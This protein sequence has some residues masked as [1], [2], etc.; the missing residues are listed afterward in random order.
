MKPTEVLTEPADPVATSPEN[1]VKAAPEVDIKR[2]P[3]AVHGV[4]SYVGDP[5]AVA[6]CPY[7]AAFRHVTVWDES[8]LEIRWISAETKFTL[9]FIGKGTPPVNVHDLLS[10]VVPL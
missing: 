9:T 2:D 1:T 8:E 6:N 7:A 4:L 3:F 5:P 10:N